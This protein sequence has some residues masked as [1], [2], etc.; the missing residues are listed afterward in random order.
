M[1][2]RKKGLVSNARFV[3][4]P[5]RALANLGSYSRTKTDSRAMPAP[6]V[7]KVAAIYT[8]RRKEKRNTRDHATFQKHAKNNKR[9]V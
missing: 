5:A 6:N 7:S 2:S 9:V 4:L 3:F 8:R 1:L